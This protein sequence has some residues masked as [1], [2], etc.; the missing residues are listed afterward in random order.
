MNFRV[1]ATLSALAIAF[2]TYLAIGGLVWTAAAQMPLVVVSAGALYLATT[3]ICV[4][5]SS[6]AL[7]TRRDP[8]TGDLGRSPVLPAGA[9]V[10]ALAAA[11][12]VPNATWLAVEPEARGADAGTWSLGAIGALLT[13]VM[14][15]RRPW[16]AWS[17]VVIL[18]AEA[19][20]WIG[21]AA[22]L[23]LGVVGA[24]LWVGVAQLLT[25]LVDRAARDTAELAALQR[26]ASEWLASQEGIRRERRTQV[27]RALA[28]AGPVLTRTI[29][30]SG[31]LSEGERHAARIAEEALRDEL[32]GSALL[33]AD[34]RAA[35]AAARERGTTVSVLDEG[36]LDG[37]SPAERAAV[38]S[39]LAAVLAEADSDRVYVRAATHDD[40]A[41]TVVGRSAADDDGEDEVDLWSEIPRRP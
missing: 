21:P 20:F 18:A 39:R 32:R 8:I 30:A 16:V 11:V 23:A 14:V 37:L 1:H 27:Q 33:D 38:R 3:W 31:R 9:A 28:L 24:V 35:L 6:G 41:V 22:A 13:I 25:W 17:G 15:R 40:V 5:W 2:T 36:G 4:F 19:A 29:E 10:L 26:A 34:V 7:P 12:L